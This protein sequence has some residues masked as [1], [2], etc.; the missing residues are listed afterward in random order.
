MV[1]TKGIAT[2]REIWSQ[3]WVVEH[4]LCPPEPELMYLERAE[5]EETGKWKREDEGEINTETGFIESVR[6]KARNAVEPNVAY[7]VALITPL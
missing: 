4:A 5:T 7:T 1:R 2:E 3:C 6:E